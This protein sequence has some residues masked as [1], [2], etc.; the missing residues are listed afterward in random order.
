[1]TFLETAVIIPIPAFFGRESFLIAGLTLITAETLLKLG[2]SLIRMLMS[3]LSE[4][5]IIPMGSSR[6]LF[7]GTGGTLF[8]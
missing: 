7:P 5:N 3:F 8:E 1:M 2:G 6:I 4:R